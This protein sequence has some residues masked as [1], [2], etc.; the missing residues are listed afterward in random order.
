MF[1]LAY[2]DYK[3]LGATYVD[4]E[5]AVLEALLDSLDSKKSEKSQF[6]SSSQNTLD[7][8]SL[9]SDAAV[10]R[11]VEAAVTRR[12]EQNVVKLIDA[13]AAQDMRLVQRMLDSEQVEVQ[14]HLVHLCS[15]GVCRLPGF[16]VARTASP[17][18]CSRH[19]HP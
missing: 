16:G 7:S 12:K 15:F 1:A 14:F 6:S 5:T 11:K 9:Q 4:D 18:D 8:V 13:V 10:L 3:Q 19:G 2:S 17:V